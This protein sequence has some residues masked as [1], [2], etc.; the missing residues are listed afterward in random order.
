MT[1]LIDKLK[2]SKI[3][4]NKK[5]LYSYTI[6]MLK[7]KDKITLQSVQNRMNVCFYQSK[8]Y[9]NKY[10]KK[11]KKYRKITL[12]R[13]KKRM[14]QPAVLKFQRNLARQQRLIYKLYNE[15]KLSKKS[16][17]IIDTKVNE[18][19]IKKSLNKYF[20]EQLKK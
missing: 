6:W 20:Q 2:K 12:Q 3:D 18:K 17:K 8:G 14:S 15:G 5:W 11:D 9:F 13:N 4:K 1:K 19:W 7:N 10:Y 16:E